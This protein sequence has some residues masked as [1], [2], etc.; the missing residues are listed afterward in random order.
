MR[1]HP[2]AFAK[3][4][5]SQASAWLPSGPDPNKKNMN[6]VFSSPCG[7]ATG[8][9]HG[10]RTLWQESGAVATGGQRNGVK[11]RAGVQFSN[12]HFPSELRALPKR[13][14]HLTSDLGSVD[15]GS[16]DKSTE[17]K[18]A[19]RREVAKWNALRALRAT[20]ASARKLHGRK[21]RDYVAAFQQMD[22]DGCV[23]ILTCTLGFLVCL[24]H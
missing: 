18:A 12:D 8:G 2:P 20:M 1:P 11:F 19:R 16:V 6:A 15:Q 5:M 23:E 22:T 10:T 21:I 17:T 7:G 14:F 24:K 3:W 4:D 9:L 13:P